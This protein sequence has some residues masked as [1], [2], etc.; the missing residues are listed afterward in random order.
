MDSYITFLEENSFA[1][2]Q[3]GLHTKEHDYFFFGG[4]LID[5]HISD[6]KME[7]FLQTNKSEFE[8]LT[9]AFLK[10]LEHIIKD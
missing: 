4:H 8:K 6:S 7:H 9:N 2:D 10:K 5:V 1:F 3:A